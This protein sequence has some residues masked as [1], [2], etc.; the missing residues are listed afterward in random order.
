MKEEVFNYIMT[1]IN[2]EIDKRNMFLEMETK[3]EFEMYQKGVIQ[4]LVMARL[5]IRAER[6]LN[7]K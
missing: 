4:G 7:E 2:A 6:T 5:I 1:D 3:E